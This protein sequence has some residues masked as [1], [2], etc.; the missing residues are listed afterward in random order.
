MDVAAAP[1]TL[2]RLQHHVRPA[3][4]GP[5]PLRDHRGHGGPRRGAEMQQR[6]AQEALARPSGDSLVL[7]DGVLTVWVSAY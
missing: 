6:G 3:R 5:L 7:S 4:L 2:L 1:A